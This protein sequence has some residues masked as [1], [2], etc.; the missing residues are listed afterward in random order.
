MVIGV[1]DTGAGIEGQDL[2]Q[3]F[4]PFFTTKSLA[5]RPGTGLGLATVDGIVT[6]AGGHIT[7]ESELGRGT[8]FCV[9]LPITAR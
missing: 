1:S 7:V 8:R 5:E 4:D 6:G 9:Y 3:I 2:D